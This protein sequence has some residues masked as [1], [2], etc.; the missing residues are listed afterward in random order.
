MEWL[1]ALLVKV[2]RQLLLE[3]HHQ[4]SRSIQ[5]RERPTLAA[6]SAEASPPAA[7]QTARNV[8][9]DL[10]KQLVSL[11]KTQKRLLKLAAVPLNAPPALIDEFS[12]VLKALGQPVTTRGGPSTNDEVDGEVVATLDALLANIESMGCENALD[13]FIDEWK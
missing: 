8:I 2:F 7:L 13:H 4:H 6:S 10:H 5:S 9:L 11:P 3:W 12:R 1:L